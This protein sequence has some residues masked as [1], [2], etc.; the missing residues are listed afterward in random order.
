MNKDRKKRWRILAAGCLANLCVGSVYAWSVFSVAMADY[1]TRLNGNEYTSGSLAIVFTIANSVGPITMIL[2]GRIN[3]ALGPR[4]VM[5]AGGLMFGAGMIG[6]GFAG[7]VSGLIIA[8]GIL[9]GLGAG[10]TYGCVIS[11][12]VKFFPDKKGLIGGITTASYGLSSV[13]IPPAADWMIRQYGI[14]H[15]FRILGIVFLLV[16][17][18]ASLFMEKCSEDSIS[19]AGSL[20]Q[21]NTEDGEPYNAAWRE[22]L[23]SPVFYVMMLI[24]LC[25]AFCGLMCTSQAAGLAQ[26]MMGLSM[27]AAALTVSVLALFNASGRILA[28]YLSDKLGRIHTLSLACF[29]SMIGQ[30]CLYFAESSGIA[31]FY[32]GICLAG[33]C[34]GALMGIFPGFTADEFG[35]KNNSVNYGIVFIGFALAGYFGPSLMR[36]VYEI[37]GSYR[38]AFLAAAFL[39]AAG[40]FLSAVVYKRVKNKGSVQIKRE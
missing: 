38:R 25:G 24:L 4:R 37:D 18:G 26:N 6:C 12:C 17:C 13:I 30:M 11:T 33:V 34:F 9:G 7:S 23:K 39:A 31:I 36:L 16:I 32:L 10:M 20:K 2:G 28:G 3:D 21:P 40:L 22:M 35:T 8:Y 29:L 19:R 5:L 27:S 14:L 15:T 1:L